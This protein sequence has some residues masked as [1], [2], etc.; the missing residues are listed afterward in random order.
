ML[1]AKGLLSSL[2]LHP[3]PSL[4]WFLTRQKFKKQMGNYITSSD[5][6]AHPAATLCRGRDGGCNLHGEQPG[7]SDTVSRQH[8]RREGRRE[9]ETSPTTCPAYVSSEPRQKK[10]EIKKNQTNLKSQT[11]SRNTFPAICLQCLGCHF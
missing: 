10:F 2:S 1:F 8:P 6:A 7:W 9:R 3:F 4:L 5:Q 11:E